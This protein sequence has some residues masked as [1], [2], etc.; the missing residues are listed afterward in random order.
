MAAEWLGDGIDKIFLPDTKGLGLSSVDG[1]TRSRSVEAAEKDKFRL[2]SKCLELHQPHSSRLVWAWKQ[3]EKISCPWLL[4]FSSLETQLT[5]AELSEAV[6]A[7][8][9]LSFT[10]M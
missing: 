3:R 8:L 7:D 4:A 10:I 5:S 2:L 1:Q 9:C 6:A